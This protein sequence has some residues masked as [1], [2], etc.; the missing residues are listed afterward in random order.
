MIRIGTRGSELALWQARR[1]AQL[2]HET[3]G[4]Q[5][6]LVIV[7]TRGDLDRS[8]VLHTLPDTG[9]FTKELQRALL[10]R[11]VDL[12][13]HS[14][15]DLPI[16]EPEGLTLAAVL[17]REATHDVLVAHPDA[18]GDGPFGLRAGARLGTSSL[19]RAAQVLACQ[20]DVHIVPLRGNVPTRVERVRQGEVK[21]TL[22]AGAGLARL[23]L[24]LD[25]VVV[26]PLPLEVM[27]PAPGQGALAVEAR[28][29][30]AAAAV[31]GQLDDPAVRE[32][33]SAERAVL[34]GLG[35]GCH[36]PLGALARR[37]AAGLTLAAVLGQLDEGL[38]RATLR[39]ASACADSGAEA[40]RQVL[41]QLAGAL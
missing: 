20:G 30:S 1:V 4:V 15:K 10:D 8:R 39:R 14:L 6:E 41:D 2:L 35:G 17:A 19:R 11:R 25:G 31:A 13:V 28:Q 21:A 5:V 3:A 26:R 12:V 33:T 34:R 36:L 38:T 32:A 16:D 22:L 7:H 27:L 24:D 40:A 29:A 37:T 9:F 23:Q 18:L